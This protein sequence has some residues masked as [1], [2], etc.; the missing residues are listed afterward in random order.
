MRRVKASHDPAR[1]LWLLAALVLAGGVLLL[2]RPAEENLSAVDAQSDA[3]LQQSLSAEQALRER[4]RVQEIASH[5]REE[6]A[7]VTLRDT[8]SESMEALLGDVQGVAARDSLT[9]SEV[10]PTAPFE[11]PAASLA[12]PPASG[13]PLDAAQ[14]N[15][16]DISVRGSYRDIVEF[17]RDLSHMP[18]LTRVVSAELERSSTGLA[19]DGSPLLDATVHVQTIRLDPTAL[20]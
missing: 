13:N 17:L 12:T 4:A 10:R 19:P 11:S 16:Y 18:T 1:L 2:I 14:K 20:Q 8:A 5:I 3:L 15:D 6:L 9:V 7:G